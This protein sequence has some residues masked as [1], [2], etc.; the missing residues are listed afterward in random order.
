MATFFQKA[1]NKGIC[2]P[3]HGE[4]LEGLPFPLTSKGTGMCP[5]SG[6]SFDYSVELDEESNVVDKFGN[7]SKA[8]KF[9]LEGND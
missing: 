9:K 6:C 8:K 7:V 4:P 3:N 2:C 1:T 5:V